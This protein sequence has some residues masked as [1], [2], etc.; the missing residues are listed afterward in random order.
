MT[1]QDERCYM[2]FSCIHYFLFVYF[3]I[4]NLGRLKTIGTHPLG[5][6]KICMCWIKA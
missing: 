3:L 4:P 2:D 5:L 6:W 1:E